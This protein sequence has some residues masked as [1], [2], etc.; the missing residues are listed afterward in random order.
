MLYEMEGMPGVPMDDVQEVSCHVSAFN[1]GIKRI[2]ENFPITYRLITEMHQV[3]M[4]SGRGVNRCPGEFR[5]SQ[6]CIGSH[7]PDEANFVPAPANELAIAGSDLSTIQQR[8]KVYCSLPRFFVLL[9][10]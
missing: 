2:R 5:K 6:V 9:I 8:F 4:T 10:P 3:L 7:R 1:L